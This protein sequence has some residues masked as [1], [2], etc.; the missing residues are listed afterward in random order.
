MA[1]KTS[2]PLPRGWTIGDAITPVL[3]R[4]KDLE[5]D[6]TTTRLQELKT[7]R[8]QELKMRGSPGLT[9]SSDPE[10]TIAGHSELKTR[11][12]KD[13]RCHLHSNNKLLLYRHIHKAHVFSAGL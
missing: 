8:N 4:F 7:P 10:P 2:R 1:K 5:E 12:N 11:S 6:E 3:N 13:L 9:T